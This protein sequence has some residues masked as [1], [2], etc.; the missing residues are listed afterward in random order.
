MS[1]IFKKNSNKEKL[2]EILINFLSEYCIFENNYYVINNEFFKKYKINNKLESFIIKLL[3][4]Y[5]NSKKYFLERE[6]N[7]N[8]LLTII[9]QICKHLNIEYTKKILY[10]KNNYNIQ[11]NIYIINL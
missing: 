5:I 9:R 6:I 1:T 3:E 10:N 2:K 11:Y 4:F 8:A 7:F